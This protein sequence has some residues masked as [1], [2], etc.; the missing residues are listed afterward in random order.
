M[1]ATN[2]RITSLSV[3]NGQ[4]SD[5]ITKQN[6]LSI[7]SES[8]KKGFGFGQLSWCDQRQFVF[9]SSSWCHILVGPPQLTQLV[10]P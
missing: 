5:F 3:N 4:M 9:L 8:I 6:E 10:Y 1:A 2:L 7:G